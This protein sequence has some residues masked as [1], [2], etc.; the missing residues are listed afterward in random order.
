[1]DRP[2]DRIATA[3][4]SL[5]SCYSTWYSI[6]VF[7][8]E[9]KDWRRIDPIDSRCKGSLESAR[10]NILGKL[11]RGQ[12]SL[13]KTF[14]GFYILGQIAC[15]LLVAIILI[16]SYRNH[17]GTLGFIFGFLIISCYWIIAAVGVWRSASTYLAS[18]IWMT[19][20]WAVAARAVVVLIAARAV[21]GLANGGALELMERMTAPMDF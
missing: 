1:M 10:M 15:F 20:A 6:I 8:A 7:E 17:L 12:Y 18:P 9:K 16:I 5:R 3:R 2:I 13:P 14:W 4:R 21:W 11:W 19:R